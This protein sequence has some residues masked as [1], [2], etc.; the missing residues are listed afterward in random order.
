MANPGAPTRDPARFI[1]EQTALRPVP[2]APEIVLHVADEATALWQKTEEELEAIGLPPPFWAFA[3]AGGQALARYILDNP[4][5]V[6]GRRVV[7]FASGSGLVAIAA[8]MAGAAHVTASD[9]DPFALHAIPLNAAANGVAA[10]IT[11]DG[12]DLIGSDAECVLAA[13]IFYERDLAA[14]VG[15]WLGDLHGRGRTVLIGDPGRSYLPRER[16]VAVA[17]YEVPVTRALEDAEIKRSSVW[18]F[19]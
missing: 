14:A 19:A 2:H 15:G 16:L 18:R 17:T 4:A 6:A 10:R 3:W 7:D 13:D 1:R 8:A 12:S 11:A 9:L 5:T